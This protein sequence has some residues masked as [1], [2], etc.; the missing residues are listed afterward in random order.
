MTDLFGNID[1]E[2]V[3][4]M[5]I[6]VPL[7]EKIE[8]AIGLIRLYENQALALSPDGY[9]VCFSGGKDSIVMEDLFRLSGVCY[10]NH[11]SNV[12]IDPP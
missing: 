12:T 6:A 4:Q 10:S 7:V 11:Y 1:E 3:Y 2:G 5:A 9:Y 8:S